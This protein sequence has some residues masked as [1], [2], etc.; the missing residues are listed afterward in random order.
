LFAPAIIAVHV[1]NIGNSTTA[2]ASELYFISRTAHYVV[3]TLG[4]VALRTLAFFCG[5]V[6]TALILYRLLE[7]VPV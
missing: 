1:L 4:I 2:F 6:G 7:A 5:W 3:Y